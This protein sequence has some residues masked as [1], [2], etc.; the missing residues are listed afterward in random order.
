[1]KVSCIRHGITADNVQ[2]IFRGLGGSGLTE[3]QGEELDSIAFDGSAYDAV[4]CS[5][6]AR[7]KETAQGLGLSSFLEDPRLVERNFGVF[8]GRSVPECQQAFPDEFVAFQ[9]LEADFVIPGGESRAQHLERILSWL[10]DV[11]SVDENVLAV[12]HGGTIDFLYRLGTDHD[13]HGGD[14]LFAGP[15]VGLSVFEVLWPDVTLVTYGEA[16]VG[17]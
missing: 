16:L 1:M 3:E 10:R 7:C 2:G 13:L 17:R 12:T 9:R 6:S 14:H 15:N 8:D 11:S 5:P 4:Y